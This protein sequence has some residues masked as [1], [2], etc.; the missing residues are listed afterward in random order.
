MTDEKFTFIEDCK[1]KKRTA[2]GAHNK[3][4]HCGKGGAVMF[5]SDYLTT[6]EKKAMNGECKAYRMNAPMTWKEFKAMPEDLQIDYIKAIRKKFGNNNKVIFDM[7]GVSVTAG[8]KHF[9]KLGLILGKN[10]SRKFD[11]EAWTRWVNGLPAA[12]VEEPQVT[13]YDEAAIEEYVEKD[14]A[15]T[16]QVI[17]QVTDPDEFMAL[18][19]AQ[20][21]SDADIRDLSNSVSYIRIPKYDTHNEASICSGRLGLEGS[22]YDI[23][24]RI[25]TIIGNENV[26]MTISWE[27]KE[28]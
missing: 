13:C 3:R 21:N 22:V 19:N 15:M 20:S 17:K 12:P 11:E 25:G 8:V 1:D 16:E 6:K 14:I 28:D 24:Q 7:F 2:R 18:Q 26:R 5:P 23:L 27:V 9:K 10:A 4:T